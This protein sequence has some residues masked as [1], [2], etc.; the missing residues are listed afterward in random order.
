M[1]YFLSGANK[2]SVTPKLQWRRIGDVNIV[3]IRGFFTEPWLKRN[4]EE[5]LAI[6]DRHPSTGLLVDV[7]EIEKVDHPGAELILEAVRKPVRGGILGHN[8][9]AY[10]VAEHMR[11]GEPIQI[12]EKGSEAVG[13]FE[14]E[15]TEGEP[16]ARGEMR[17]FLR[18][19]TALPV[20]FEVRGEAASS[21]FEAVVL[22]LSEGGFYGRFLDSRSE[23]LA[24]R[25]LD[26]FDLKLIKVRLHLKTKK[27][28]KAEGKVLRTEKRMSERGGVA[29]EFYNLSLE[30]RKSIQQ[31]LCSEEERQDK[32]NAL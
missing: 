23:E 29:V 10:F 16:S 22:N 1:L 28:V 5:M 6:L 3:E 27:I 21:V 25:M 4:R 32:G 31:F 13:F 30:D 9:S 14:K 20:E 2:I 12:F 15:L 11:P 24:E 26:P 8:L 19:K 17:R 18:V 7:R